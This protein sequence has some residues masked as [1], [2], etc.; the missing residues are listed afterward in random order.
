MQKSSA[1]TRRPLASPVASSPG[2]LACWGE[3]HSS[4]CRPHSL[5]VE[6]HPRVA[7]SSRKSSAERLKQGSEMETWGLRVYLR[8]GSARISN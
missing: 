1:K 4:Y 3:P 2:H 6:G 7:D 5:A 8:Q